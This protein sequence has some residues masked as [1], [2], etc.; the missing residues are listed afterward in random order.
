M[1]TARRAAWSG[2][3]EA[4]A[5]AAVLATHV[6]GWGPMELHQLTGAIGFTNEYDLRLSTMGVYAVRQEAGGL[7]AHSRG[8]VDAR[9]GDVWTSS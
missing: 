2:D 4:A 3:A 1:W 7:P 8:L 6:G 5:N 9:W